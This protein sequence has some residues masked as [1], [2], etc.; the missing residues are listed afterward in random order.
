MISH[1]NTGY[2]EDLS[3][4]LKNHVSGGVNVLLRNELWNTFQVEGTDT[5]RTYD[6]FLVRARAYVNFEWENLSVYVMGQGV[7]AFNLPENAAFGPG[8]LYYDASDQKTGPGNFQFVE[9]SSEKSQR[10][11]STGRQNR[12]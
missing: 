8:M 2:G 6:F 10:I 9:A 5:D 1:A 3:G 4:S 11:F 12:L 7:K